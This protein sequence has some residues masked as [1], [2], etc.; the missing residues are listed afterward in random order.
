M[1]DRSMSPDPLSLS[2]ILVSFSRARHAQAPHLVHRLP[3]LLP[4]YRGGPWGP[5]TVGAG[6][7]LYSGLAGFGQ[8]PVRM[9]GRKGS[10][11][12]VPLLRQ[13]GLRASG[14]FEDA[15]TDDTRLCLA[16]VTA[17]AGA[18]AVGN[19]LLMQLQADVLGVPVVRPVV[20]E[21]TALGAAYAAGLAVGFW[22]GLRELRRHQRV[23]RVFRP[24]WDR[25]RREAGLRLWKRAVARTRGWIEA[26]EAGGAGE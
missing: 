4:F 22:S 7:V 18:G 26:P 16:T 15:Q 17:A 23:D 6:L 9:L 3:F 19:N 12:M 8:G 2:A 20:G 13:D 10:R 5:V 21:A 14:L 24:R 11:A 25:R 1:I